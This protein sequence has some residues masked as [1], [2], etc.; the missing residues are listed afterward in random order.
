MEQTLIGLQ[1]LPFAIIRLDRIGEDP[2]P[3]KG[4][5][6]KVISC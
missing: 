4:V 5:I 6:E 3:S 1:K 2:K